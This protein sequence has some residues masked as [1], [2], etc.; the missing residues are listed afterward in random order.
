MIIDIHCHT[1][2]HKLWGLHTESATIEDLEK[3]A[4]RHGV[5]KIVLL[6]TYFPLKKSG[7]HNR[8]LLQRIDDND[9]FIAFG[10]LDMTGDI[11]AGILELEELIKGGNISG[12][13]LYPGYQDFD[14]GGAKVFPMYELAE[15]YDLPVM[16]H[17][18]ELHGCCP[19]S[20]R[21]KF[22]RTCRSRE[23]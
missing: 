17:G 18:G 15:S 4:L 13:K 19:R 11:S 10:S 9:L 20:D 21:E 6:A 1:S 8:E 2:D 14:P 23:L 16:F 12:I 7:L 22:C 3:Y 5:K